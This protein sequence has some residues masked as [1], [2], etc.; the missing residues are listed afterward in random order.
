MQKILSFA[1]LFIKREF[2]KNYFITYLM[3]SIK[4]IVLTNIIYHLR[5]SHLPLENTCIILSSFNI[6][7]S[8]SQLILISPV[9]LWFS[10]K[11]GFKEKTDKQFSIES[12]VN[13]EKLIKDS[14]IPI[15]LPALVFESV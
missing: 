14:K 12:F 10:K 4:I 13:S 15:E 1:L 2:D 7:K 5:Y 11:A 8:A 3:L 6:I 9:H